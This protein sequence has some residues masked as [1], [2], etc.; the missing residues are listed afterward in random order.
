MKVLPKFKKIETLEA[1]KYD[2]K[3]KVLFE[4]DEITQE[5][6]DGILYETVIAEFTRRNGK[7][8]K[9]RSTNEL[10]LLDGECLIKTD[11]GYQLPNVEMTELTKKDEE[12]IE[13]LNRLV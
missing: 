11:K 1:I 7:R 4:N 8:V 12:R 13:K 3:D 10:E 2:G 6:K 9:Q 5:I